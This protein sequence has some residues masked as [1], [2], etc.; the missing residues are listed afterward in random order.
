MPAPQPPQPLHIA[1]LGAS[2]SGL[3]LAIGLSAHPHISYMLYD[4]SPAPH[5]L[6]AGIAF[7]PNA[8]LAMALL[9][10]RF[11]AA[12]DAIATGN[13]GPGKEHVFHDVLLCEPG[14]GRAQGWEGESV[15]YECYW[16]SSCLRTE[17]LGVMMALVPKERVM[18]GKRAVGVDQGGG[19]AVVA[20][21][22]GGRVEADA[23]VGCDGGKGVVR[24]AVL[25]GDGVVDAVYAGRYVY[26]AVV[27]M[28]E[29]RGILGEYA[30]DG[31]MFV[32]KGTYFATY[33]M[34]GGA[35]LNFL[36]GRQDDMPWTHEQWTEEVPR[37][38]MVKD[39]EGCDE[40]LVKL[41]DVSL[42]SPL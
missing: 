26:R 38:E 15:E 7:G 25:E 34:A 36:A 16:K 28:E 35:Q 39:F 22:D 13:E 27:P 8:L 41:L 31:K 20:F 1:I 23:V 30:R 42:I 3:A 14:L 11:R 24:R 19:R 6:G 17:L 2:I 32:G 33:A 37:E 5:A 18:F 4:A 12:Y 21:A 9:D 29:A 10:P 40:R